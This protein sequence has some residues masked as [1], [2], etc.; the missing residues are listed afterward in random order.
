M[1]NP[2]LDIP[3]DDY[4]GHM[5]HPA[6]NQRS[7]LNR[8]VRE[9]LEEVKPHGFLVLGCSTG[10]G[11]EH[12]DR[13]VTERVTVIDINSLYL[14]RL[15]ERFQNPGF[16]LEIRCADV[17]EVVLEPDAFD[18]V[19]AALLFEYVDWQPLI[20]RVVQTLTPGG[21]LSVVLQRR[22]TSIPVVTPTPFRS[23]QSLESLFRIVDP[24]ALIDAATTAGLNLVH[25]RTD[26]L[27]SGKAFEVMRFKK[28]S[29]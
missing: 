3:A 21:V 8:L 18:L 14:N 6:V 17:D 5:S 15:G 23:L 26:F 2:W 22:S 1:T 9:A 16:E 12:V 19:H 29:G 11:L 7:V 27:L 13:T 4:V 20:V 10:N 28:D 24:D 25:R